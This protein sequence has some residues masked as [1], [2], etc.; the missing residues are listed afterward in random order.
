M[1]DLAFIRLRLTVQ[2]RKGQS[3]DSECEGEI[4][5]KREDK[6]KRM[7]RR[8]DKRS[9]QLTKIIPLRHPE[10]VHPKLQQ[11]RLS[12]VQCSAQRGPKE[13]LDRP[14]GANR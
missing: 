8:R 14:Q 13:L 5:E 7:E 2:K 3:H 6:K 9:L 12:P 11:L 4:D 10:D 1:E